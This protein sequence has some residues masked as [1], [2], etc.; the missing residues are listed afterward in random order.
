MLYSYEGNGF[1]FQLRTDSIYESR[2]FYFTTF[3]M[4]VKEHEEGM[5]FHIMWRKLSDL[6]SFELDKKGRLKDVD[7]MFIRS[8]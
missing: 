8:Y 2:T 7:K 3:T 1:N 5:R 4:V 6:K